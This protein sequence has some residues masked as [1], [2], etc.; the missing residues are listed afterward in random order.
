[1]VVLALAL[2]V[3]FHASAV[4]EVRSIPDKQPAHPGQPYHVVAEVVWHGDPGEFAVA[5][6]VDAVDWGTVEVIAAKSFVRDGA[7]VLSYTVSIVPSE[8]GAFMTP[9]IAMAY[10]APEEFAAP[11]G[12]AGEPAIP[13]DHGLERLHVAPFPVRVAP[14][15]TAAW[16]CSVA[17]IVARLM[18]LA[19]WTKRRRRTAK[20][21]IVL[22]T[23][24]TE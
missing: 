14:D 24:D 1:M 16:V 19:W 15:R 8:T 17:A 18:G 6:Q 12:V 10:G 20:S 4:P 3:Q 9:K 22:D 2:A 11:G 5:P 23:S 7:N 13:A 21:E